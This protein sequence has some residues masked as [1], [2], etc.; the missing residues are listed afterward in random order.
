[1]YQNIY[2]NLNIQLLRF[3]SAYLLII[4]IFVQFKI[5]I[6]GHFRTNQT[7]WLV[8]WE[9]K[10]VFPFYWPAIWPVFQLHLIVWDS[11]T[12]NFRGHGEIGNFKELLRKRCFQPPPPPPPLW[13]TSQPPP[14]PS[15]THFQSSSAGPEFITYCGFEKCFSKNYIDWN[16]RIFLWLN[17]V[18]PNLKQYFFFSFHSAGFFFLEFIFALLDCIF[19]AT[20]GTTFQMVCHRWEAS[21]LKHNLNFVTAI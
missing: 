17:I 3:Y 15:P 9:I 12:N 18:I 4:S 11:K 19:T 13:V 14:S 7:T 5:L 1:M 10:L 8:K 2:C 16:A 6:L 21:D 20:L